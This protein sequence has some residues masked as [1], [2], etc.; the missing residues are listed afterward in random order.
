[1]KIGEFFIK[2]YKL[3]IRGMIK[4]DNYEIKE[5]RSKLF[6][7]MEFKINMVKELG[8]WVWEGWFYRR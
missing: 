2:K 3:D 4:G 6:L 8:F 1:M 5:V 7:E